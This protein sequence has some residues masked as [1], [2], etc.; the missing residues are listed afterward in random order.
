MIIVEA[1]ENTSDTKF[2]GERLRG[3]S[4]AWFGYF[5]DGLDFAVM[6]FIISDISREFDLSLAAASSLVGAVYTTR[7]IAGPIIGSIS[8]RWGRRPAMAASVLM[9]SLA[10]MACAFSPSFLALFLCRA[11]VGI[12]MA[13]V[14]ASCATYAVE[15]APPGRVNI[16]SAMLNACFALGSGTAGWLYA[17][18]VPEYGWRTLMMAGS[19]PVLI[20]LLLI[21]LA[22]ESHVWRQSRAVPSE[23]G[24]S[25][26]QVFSRLW[27]RVTVLLCLTMV[28][29]FIAA[30]PVQ[31]L[32]PTYLRQ[33]GY[34][35]IQLGTIHSFGALGMISGAVL[36]GLA[37]DRL[38]TRRVIC[39]SLLF[40]LTMI[41]PIFLFSK[42]S[43]PFT[44]GFMFAATLLTLG[45]AA[46]MPKW[47]AGHYPTHLRGAGLGTV[48]NFGALGGFMGPS[49]VALLSS[50]AG[51]EV[52]IIAT[53]IL[54]VGVT[55]CIVGLRL[56]ERV[57]APGT[58]NQVQL[59]NSG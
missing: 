52:A 13:G 48:Y 49:L 51:L 42:S 43:V 41:G 56:P 2:T 34:S 54:F 47:I 20:S 15:I 8:D 19:S 22:P 28:A 26:A 57:F 55:I 17:L 6:I 7:W 30:M 1:S 9:C 46:L 39:I 44:A 24:P 45:V 50:V 36:A 14:T 29:L 16:A 3:L 4:A 58:S 10:T 27:W 53:S 33:I 21:Y 12:G 31:I 23:K 11:V 5:L 32:L 38:G 37:A 35:P 18:V 25:A 59:P 40:S